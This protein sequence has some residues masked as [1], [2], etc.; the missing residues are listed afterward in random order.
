[1]S[2]SDLELKKRD[3]PEMVLI[4]FLIFAHLFILFIG[5][6]ERTIATTYFAQERHQG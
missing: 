3:R 5:K 6:L 1:M 2:D 4:V